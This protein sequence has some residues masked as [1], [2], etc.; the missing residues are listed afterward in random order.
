MKLGKITFGFAAVALMAAPVL[1]Q[2]TLTPAIAPLSGDETAVEGEGLLIGAVVTAAV[3]VGVLV[4]SDG[5][6]EPVSP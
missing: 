4:A 3:V 2:A 1:A 5:K 6:S